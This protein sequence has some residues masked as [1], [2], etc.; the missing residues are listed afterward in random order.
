[1]SGDVVSVMDCGALSTG[2][3]LLTQLQAVVGAV[4]AM[5]CTGHC[6]ALLTQLQTV[7]D[8]VWSMVCT[9]PRQGHL[10]YRPGCTTLCG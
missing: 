8:A 5:V 6:L 9:G 3:A 2:L 7:V 4:W 10:Q 1:M